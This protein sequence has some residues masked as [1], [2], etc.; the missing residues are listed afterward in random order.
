MV[1]LYVPLNS[2]GLLINPITCK[3]QALMMNPS[4]SPDAIQGQP[5]PYQVKALASRTTED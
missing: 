5:W 1:A 3:P 2:H 4:K